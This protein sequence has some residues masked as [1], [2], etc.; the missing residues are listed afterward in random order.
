[1]KQLCDDGMDVVA[2]CYPN[3]DNVDVRAKRIQCSIFEIDEPYDYFEK[4]VVVLHLACRNG[5]VHN[6][7][8]H[9]DDLPKHYHFLKNCID[10]GCVK[11]SSYGN[12]A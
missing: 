8:S 10:S 4:T 3:C 1:M 5:F 12:H 9:I 6:D 7:A 11:N 2:V